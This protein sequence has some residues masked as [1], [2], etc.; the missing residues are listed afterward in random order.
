MDLLGALSTFSR[1]AET[2]SFSAVARERNISHTAVTRL[3]GQ[4]EEHFGARLLQRSTRHL[5]LTEDGQ[6]VLGYARQLLETA[7]EMQ[8]ALG[9]Q[10]AS[11]TGLVRVGLPV[12]ASRWVMPRLPRM[13]ERYPG[14]AVELVVAD[15]FGDLIE[16]RLDLAL[17]GWAPQDSST[18][19]RVVGSFGRVAVASGPY[20]ERRG[21]PAHPSD[22]ANH[23]CI[24]HELGP[25]SA[26]WNFQ[27]PEGE[28]EV[29]VSGAIRANSSEACRQAALADYGVAQLSEMTVADDVRAGR[30]YR[31]LTEFAP[32]RQ[33]I[34]LVYPSRRHLAP[35]VRAVIEFMADGVRQMNAYLSDQ[36]VWGEIDAH[37]V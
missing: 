26:R 36:R 7:D 30:L 29:Q 12:A 31:V 24:L 27:G 18:I 32:P 6:N 16:E 21:S 9:R 22:L 5:N 33:S 13:L 11:P 8:G 15:G 25:D 3:I 4:L 28:I 37:L 23:T 17:T 34:Y 1:V 20:L 19:A 14:L 35:R 10:S 2:G